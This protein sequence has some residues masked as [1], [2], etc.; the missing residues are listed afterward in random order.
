[1]AAAQQPVCIAI[2]MTPAAFFSNLMASV[3]ARNEEEA[4]MKAP[5]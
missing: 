4:Y 2:Q 5:L 3:D 1:V